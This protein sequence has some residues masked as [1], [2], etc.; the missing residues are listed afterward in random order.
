MKVIGMAL[1][2]LIGGFIGG[3][4]LTEIVAVMAVLLLGQQPWLRFLK[5]SPIWIAVLC[6][7]AVVISYNRTRA[8][9]VAGG[10]SDV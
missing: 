7:V 2:G 3:I 10:R 6:A 4:M 9:S 1:L 8:K 5:Y